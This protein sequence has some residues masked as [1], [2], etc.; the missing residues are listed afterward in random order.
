[1]YFISHRPAAGT[2]RQKS[3]PLDNFRVWVENKDGKEDGRKEGI[4]GDGGC[5]LQEGEEGE[6]EGGK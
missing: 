5:D 3:A 1:M 2:D 6:N 4:G